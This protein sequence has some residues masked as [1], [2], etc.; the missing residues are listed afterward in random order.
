M[1]GNFIFFLLYDFEFK[2]KC[3]LIFFFY[4]LLQLL[5]V[6]LVVISWASILALLSRMVIALI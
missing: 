2:V 6:C 3:G 1:E 5:G 4:G